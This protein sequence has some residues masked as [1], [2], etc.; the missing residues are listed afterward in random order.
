MRVS[1]TALRL[2][3]PM[4]CATG[5]AFEVAGQQALEVYLVTALPQCTHDYST[6]DGLSAACHSAVGTIIPPFAT[7]HG[8]HTIIRIPL[9]SV[10]ALAPCTYYT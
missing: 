1:T 10:C 9:M 5:K 2:P 6:L 3:R 4:P 7:C 8:G